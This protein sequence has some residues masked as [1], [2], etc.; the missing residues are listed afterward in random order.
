MIYQIFTLSGQFY[1][2]CDNFWVNLTYFRINP[3]VLA[4]LTQKIFVRN[5]AQVP[6]FG[7]AGFKVK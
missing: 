2:D 3:Y 7:I 1:N 6:R 5:F 4:Q